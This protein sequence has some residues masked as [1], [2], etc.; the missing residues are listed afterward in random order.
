ME[1]QRSLVGSRRVQEGPGG[2]CKVR[3]CMEGP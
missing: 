3:K 1:G 2:S